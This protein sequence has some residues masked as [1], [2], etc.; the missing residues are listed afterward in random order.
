M[1]GATNAKALS[2]MLG[3]KAPSPLAAAKGQPQ[4]K[5]AGDREGDACSTVGQSYSGCD[6][7]ISDSTCCPADCTT[8]WVSACNWLGPDSRSGIKHD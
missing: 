4:P 7:S 1:S 3:V 8:A 5:A 2:A 6:S